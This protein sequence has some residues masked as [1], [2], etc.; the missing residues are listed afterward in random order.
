MGL[1]NRAEDNKVSQTNR[2]IEAAQKLSIREKRLVMFAA[3]RI[4]SR[5]YRP[6]DVPFIRV[7]VEDFSR[8]FGIAKTSA[9]SE[10]NASVKELWTSELSFVLD[11]GSLDESIR[12]LQ[13]KRL[14]P[15]KPY[16][17]IKFSNDVYA[18]LT[19]IN[20]DFTSFELRQLGRLETFHAMRVYELCRRYKTTG[21]RIDNLER[22]KLILGV[23][24]KYSSVKD[25]RRWVLDP[26]I[27]D[28]NK[29]TDL[30]VEIEPMKRGRKIT[31]FSFIIDAKD[32]VPL[33]R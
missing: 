32:V 3:S 27:K 20:R 4:D 2:L 25:F 6:A 7:P 30:H 14:H 28:I 5:K 13:N 29:N 1:P 15:R 33:V 9:P 24:G 21:N 10:L 26:S 12:W 23:A 31:G 8:V 22:L 17:D 16:V 19:E 18:E 11:D